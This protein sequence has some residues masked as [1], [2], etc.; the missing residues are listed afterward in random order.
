MRGSVTLPLRLRQQFLTAE[1]VAQSL[2]ADKRVAYVTYPGLESHDQHQVAKKQ[3]PAR[4][5]AR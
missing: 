3:S 2:A 1:L 5:M 4:A